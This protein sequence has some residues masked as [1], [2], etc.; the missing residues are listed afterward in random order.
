MRHYHILIA[1][2]A[3]T[4]IFDTDAITLLPPATLRCCYCFAAACHYRRFFTFAAFDADFIA[5]AD[6]HYAHT[7][8][9]QRAMRDV[10]PSR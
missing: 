4:L 9:F 10:T 2:Y 7:L 5:A 8:R 3:A 6:R 1:P